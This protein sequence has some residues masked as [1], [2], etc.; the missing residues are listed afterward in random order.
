MSMSMPVALGMR[1]VSVSVSVCVPSSA[2]LPG[3]IDVSVSC[4]VQHP[5][6]QRLR[7]PLTCLYGTQ[8]R[9]S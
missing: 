1:H 2:Y 4:L 6:T 7:V 3:S 5:T 8:Q 9:E